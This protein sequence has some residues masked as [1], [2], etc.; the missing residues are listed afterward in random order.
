MKSK[1]LA[2]SISLAILSA[3]PAFCA[4]PA[5]EAPPPPPPPPPTLTSM[6]NCYASGGGL[7]ACAA[8][9]EHMVEIGNKV[10]DAKSAW[11]T[12]GFINYVSAISFLNQDSSW[13]DPTGNLDNQAILAAVAKFIRENPDKVSSPAAVLTNTA[14][15]TNFP[16]T[17]KP[18]HG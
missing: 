12:S 10:E 7:A 14:L 2:L 4:K 1:L 9:W 18:G 3:P 8:S 11:E 16:C 6:V 13:C 5:P 15:K 17:K